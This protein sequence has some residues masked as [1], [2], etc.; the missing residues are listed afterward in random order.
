MV[1]T[2]AKKKTFLSVKFVSFFNMIT[3]QFNRLTPIDFFPPS[4]FSI[5]EK[6]KYLLGAECAEYG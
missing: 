1:S 2:R 6:R 3:F 4:H 5:L